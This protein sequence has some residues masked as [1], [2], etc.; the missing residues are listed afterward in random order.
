MTVNTCIN[1]KHLLQSNVSISDFSERVNFASLY[2]SFSI[3][4]LRRKTTLRTWLEVG[5]SKLAAQGLSCDTLHVFAFLL[6]VFKLLRG[7]FTLLQ[8]FTQPPLGKVTGITTANGEDWECKCCVRVGY[9][10][11]FA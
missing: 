2:R 1:L 9:P 11:L 5:S 7:S 4:G 3:L 6:L 8:G 10:K